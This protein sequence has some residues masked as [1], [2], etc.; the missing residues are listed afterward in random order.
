MYLS[1]LRAARRTPVLANE[2]ASLRYSP[3]TWGKYRMI[4]IEPLL[5]KILIA[6]NEAS[7]NI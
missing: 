6:L 7:I 4:F 1:N 5:K 3:P 2:R